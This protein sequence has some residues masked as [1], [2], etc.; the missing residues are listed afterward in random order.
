MLLKIKRIIM[1]KFEKK[2]RN[3]LLIR[4]FPN[5]KLINNRGLINA[6]IDETILAVV[7]NSNMPVVGDSALIIDE[8]KD[9]HPYE[10]WDNGA[11]MY[12]CPK[13]KE[14]VI[15]HGDNNC[16]NCGQKLEWRYH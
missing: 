16:S 9:E 4:G 14:A 10:Q 7:K 13:C 12:I 5:D 1:D 3:K 6:T 8:I 11:P 15:G 2:I